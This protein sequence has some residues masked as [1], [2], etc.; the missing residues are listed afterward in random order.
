MYFMPGEIMIHLRFVSIRVSI[1]TQRRLF[2]N[3][4]EAEQRAAS[5]NKNLQ[6]DC[7]PKM[8][9]IPNSYVNSYPI[10]GWIMSPNRKG[11]RFRIWGCRFKSYHDLERQL[12]LSSDNKINVYAGRNSCPFSFVPICIL[13]NLVRFLD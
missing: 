10:M 2:Q 3:A 1:A 5:N 8:I 7:W 11:T 13:A 12:N 6:L 9:I 4:K